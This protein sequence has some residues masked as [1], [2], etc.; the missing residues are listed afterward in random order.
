MRAIN[1]Q[2]LGAPM[3]YSNG[4]LVATDARLLF[5]AGQIGWNSRQ[6][7]VSEEFGA[8]FGRALA[9]VVT[10]VEAA[11]GEAHHI[12]RLTLYVTD[13]S[14]YLA[15]L[16]GLGEIYRRVMGRHYPAM[17]LVEIGALLEPGAKV[18]I[19]ATAAIPQETDLG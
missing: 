7:L 1:P 4:Q 2:D 19:E 9:N 5:I 15:D 11:G 8:Q 10:V 6:E 18:E 13:K 17:T 16:K 12:A 14:E 3:G